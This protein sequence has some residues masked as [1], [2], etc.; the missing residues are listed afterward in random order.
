MVS[1]QYSYAE[2]SGRIIR[3]IDGDQPVRYNEDIDEGTPDHTLS[4]LA[5]QVFSGG[6]QFSLAYFYVSDISWGGDGDSLPSYSRW[7][8]KIAKDFPL[9]DYAGKLGLLV[10]NLLDDAYSEFRDENIF[11]RRTYLQLSL[12]L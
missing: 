3:Q 7:D 10:Q 5:S 4:L 2:A 12:Q 6:I 1:L 9:G 11:E 8:A